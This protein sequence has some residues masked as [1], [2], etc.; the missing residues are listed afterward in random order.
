[1]FRVYSNLIRHTKQKFED[2]I[3][4]ISW[5]FLTHFLSTG[6]GKRFW[7]TPIH[8]AACPLQTFMIKSISKLS[9]FLPSIARPCFPSSI[10]ISSCSP[11]DIIST[12][13][14][15]SG[16]A[17]IDNGKLSC[18]FRAFPIHLPSK[19]FYLCKDFTTEIISNTHMYHICATK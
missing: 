13:L 3:T 17:L 2:Y 1:V 11:F 9:V 16:H 15:R 19:Q 4:Y 12:E 8:G 7:R 10:F 14:F 5:L 18:H 6:R